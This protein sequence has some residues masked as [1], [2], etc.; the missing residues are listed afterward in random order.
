[1]KITQLTENTISSV[2][3]NDTQAP[4][5]GRSDTTLES[6]VGATA[7]G[8][9]ATGTPSNLGV[10]RRNGKK[11][12]FQGIKTSKKFVNSAPVKESKE[13]SEREYKK[14]ETPVKTEIC[15]YCKRPLDKCLCSQRESVEQELDE[16][17][18]CWKDY[19]QIGMKKKGNKQVPNCVPKEGVAEGSVQ[20]ELYQRQQELRKKRGAPDP[21]Y[22]KEL[23]QSY[24]I[25]ND[26]ERYARQ[27]EIRKKYGITEGDDMVLEKSKSKA[28]FKF[29]AAAAHNPKFAKK[30]GMDVDVAKEFHKAD[31]KQS[32]KKLPD[33]ADETV[34]E[35]DLSEEQLLAKQL[36]KQL[37]LFKKG[38]DHD[39]GGKPKDHELG[40]K[41]TDKEILTKDK[42]S[43]KKG[44]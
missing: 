37:E 36:K 5:F 1:M 35:A 32:Y 27:A 7:S 17:D 8:S 44:K 38:Q 22:Y 24:N 19:K 26:Q 4:K 18:P 11:S 25:E 10:Q 40:K 12:I 13:L 23:E 2:G 21:M 3:P 28:Q 41:P 31:K 9:V 16:N 43:Y 29:M 39:L 14:V 15:K 34:T 6:S 20:D 33:R 30:A 42:K